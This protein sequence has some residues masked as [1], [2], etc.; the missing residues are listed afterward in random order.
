MKRQPA[1]TSF[2]LIE[3]LV[4]IA[5]IAIL[6]SMLLPAL[7]KAR[8]RAREIACTNQLKQMGLAT[9]MYIEEHDDRYMTNNTA[10]GSWDYKLGQYDGRSTPPTLSHNMWQEVAKGTDWSG[11]YSCPSDVAGNTNGTLYYRRSYAFNWFKAG[12]NERPGLLGVEWATHPGNESQARKSSE[13]LNP[14]NTLAI[15][16]WHANNNRINESGSLS[17]IRWG[18][19]RPANVT[20]TESSYFPHGLSKMNILYADGHVDLVSNYDA[21]RMANGNYSSAATTQ[22]D[23]E[24]E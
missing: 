19:V 4:V 11:I 14:S 10:T 6:A 20:G 9:F 13:V 8:D 3:L 18:Y 16:E 23:A 15:T 24:H 22:F 21:C 17:V 12:D 1:S 5:I 7:N 2:T